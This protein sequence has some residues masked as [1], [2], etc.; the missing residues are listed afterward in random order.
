MGRKASEEARR[1]E[2]G[3][4]ASDRDRRCCTAVVSIKLTVSRSL[5]CVKA[6]LVHATTDPSLS[7]LSSTVGLPFP[8]PPPDM[9][10]ELLSRRVTSILVSS[11]DGL[12]A[13][14]WRRLGRIQLQLQQN[15]G[16][17]RQCGRKSMI[18][19]Q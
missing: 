1:D 4:R 3:N 6:M 5:G 18:A 9:L 17:Q 8:A 2:P 11:P 16:L 13:F 15:S 12:V 14:K 7:P 19:Q 10:L